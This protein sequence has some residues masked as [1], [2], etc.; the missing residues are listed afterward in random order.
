MA[1]NGVHLISTDEMTGIQALSRA[2]PTQSMIPGQVKRIEFEY[3]RHGTVSLIANWDI[4]KG[5]VIEP[6]IGPRRTE[7][8]FV[9]HIEQTIDTDPKAGWIF[10]VDQLNT[11]MSESLVQLVASRCQINTD[12]GV[13]G[14]KGILASM[15]TRR[16]FLSDPTHR[17]RFVYL[18]KHTSW[19]N[20]IECW[21][22][23][24]TRRLLKR[25]EFTSTSD[26][27][28][29]ILKFIDYF[30]RTSAKPFLWKFEGF[31]DSN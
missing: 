5:Q 9:N 31:K 14:K 10:I 25:G 12:L 3:I 29:Q 24:L 22:S 7:I 21:F 18:P 8:D 13:K 20:Q 11:H 27:S 28:E 26:L 30:N 19:L 16:A 2:Y 6:S 23:I 15:K 4:A 1:Q 17:I